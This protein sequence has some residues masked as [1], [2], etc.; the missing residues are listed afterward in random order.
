MT[1]DLDTRCGELYPRAMKSC[2]PGTVMRIVQSEGG[3][4]DGALVGR[5]CCDG[6][7]W[8]ES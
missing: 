6:W 8:R 1:A 4:G 5:F 7:L 3:R 2:L